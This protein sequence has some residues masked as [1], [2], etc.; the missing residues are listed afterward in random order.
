MKSPRY[1]TYP[2]SRRKQDLFFKSLKK[3]HLVEYSMAYV[4]PEVKDI[5]KKYGVILEYCGSGTSAYHKYGDFI[6]QVIS[7]RVDTPEI[8]NF[9]P[10]ELVT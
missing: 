10:N 8:Y 9:D 5:A 4:L 7:T 6:C 1:L 2:M 3:G